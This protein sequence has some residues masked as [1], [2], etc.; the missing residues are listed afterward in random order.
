LTQLDRTVGTPPYMS[1]EQSIDQPVGPRSDVYS[2]GCVLHELL[3]GHRPYAEGSGRSHREQHLFAPIPSVRARRPDVPADIDDLAHAML[4]KNPADRPD[5][6]SVYE[7]LLPYAAQPLDRPAPSGAQDATLPFR[8]P[9]AA[10][11]Q[12]ANPRSAGEAPDLVP[13]S[14]PDAELLI[15]QAEELVEAGQPN[16][17]IGILEDGV[18]RAEHDPIL[19]LQMQHAL[20][21]TLFYA[22]EYTKAGPLFDDVGRRFAQ[23]L[24][25]DQPL[26]ADCAYYAGYCYAET[27]HAAQALERLRF[28]VAHTLPGDPTQQEQYRAARYLIARMLATTGNITEARGEFHDVRRLYA[29]AYGPH[30]THVKQLDRQISR[31]QDGH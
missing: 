5:A 22:D 25:D 16:R 29:E 15:E 20:A 21:G 2:L 23:D 28:Y 3:T 14:E 12:P 24:G 8:R 9:L 17:A 30:S 11:A 31:L 26:V 6:H 1:P 13:L 18:A 10:V 7:A 4:A 27:G 19:A